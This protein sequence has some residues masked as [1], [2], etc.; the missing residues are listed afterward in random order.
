[1]FSSGY[2]RVSWR[3]KQSDFLRSWNL[4]LW[5]L[6]WSNRFAFSWISFLN[7]NCL[8]IF[9]PKNWDDNILTF[10]R[11]IEAII[12]PCS[13]RN[14]VVLFHISRFE[15]FQRVICS[16]KLWNWFR[17]WKRYIFENKKKS[18]VITFLFL[19]LLYGMSEDINHKQ[20]H[21]ATPN[22]FPFMNLFVL[23][24]SWYICVSY[25]LCIHLDLALQACESQQQQ[26]QV[27]KAK[28]GKSLTWR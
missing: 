6:L 3:E 17:W 10:T 13:V 9:R 21:W 27:S 7:G 16:L 28:W 26:K 14:R 2:L 5:A 12:F 22:T 8:N 11:I 20:G 24:L 15:V 1:M 25:K 18:G 23:W 19:K 4:W